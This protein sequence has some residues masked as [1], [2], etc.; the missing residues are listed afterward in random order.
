N[1]GD[2]RIELA[3]GETYTLDIAN[4]AGQDNDNVEGDLDIQ[5]LF[6]VTGGKTY[7]FVGIGA[8]RPLISQ[9]VIDRVFQIIGSGVTVSFENVQISGGNAQDDGTA[10]TNPG[11]T[12]ALGGGVLN[13]GGAVSFSNAYVSSNSAIG[14]GGSDGS[15]GTST[16]RDGGD[17]T[18]GKNAFGGGLYSSGGT[19]TIQS[20]SFF[21]N[22]T[23][24]G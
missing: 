11:E 15:D 23:A 22:N 20:G 13:G 18:A 24:Q 17:G 8:G 5:D 21:I 19:V 2:V 14:G 10:G 3:F 9:T 4:S 1:D 7:T 12:D 16:S 6:G